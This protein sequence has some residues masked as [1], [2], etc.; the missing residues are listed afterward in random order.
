MG[1]TEVIM[2]STGE[3]TDDDGTDGEDKEVKDGAGGADDCGDDDGINVWGDR[4]E[5]KEH[6]SSL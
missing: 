1:L 4:G 5:V 2:D 3:T 6:C